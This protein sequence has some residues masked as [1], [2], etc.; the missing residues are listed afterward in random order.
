MRWDVQSRVVATFQT[1]RLTVPSVWVYFYLRTATAVA[2]VGG[3]WKKEGMWRGTGWLWDF[4]RSCR[5][6]CLFQF[7]NIQ[8]YTHLR[9]QWSHACMSTTHVDTMQTQ[10]HRRR[11]LQVKACTASQVKGEMRTKL[12]KINHFCSSVVKIGSIGLDHWLVY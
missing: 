12:K 2:V 7:R 5:P 11:T 10:T 3:R 4:S 1:D 6:G 8:T 9:A